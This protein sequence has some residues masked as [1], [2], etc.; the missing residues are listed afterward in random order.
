MTP[1]IAPTITTA[2]F[3]PSYASDSNVI[4][5]NAIYEN[6]ANGIAIV[7]AQFNKIYN[8]SI[9]DNIN[10]GLSAAYYHNT[11]LYNDFIN[12]NGGGIQASDDG[13]KNHYLFNY[14]SD[15]SGQDLDGD[16]IGDTPYNIAG[17]GNAKDYWPLILSTTVTP[18]PYDLYEEFIIDGDA[19]FITQAGL[20][21][22]SGSGTLNDPIILKNLLFITLTPGISSL[23]IRNTNLHFKIEECIIVGGTSRTLE[24]YS[25]QNGN[26]SSTVIY[27]SGLNRY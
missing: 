10:Y 21:G 16:G 13:V 9:Y 5:N 14:W 18:L 17:S 23:E 19:D 20:E 15:Y 8:N 6:A 25:V 27:H 7:R 24:L 26:I 12:N 2:D 22:W 1:P 11:I 3:F 4:F